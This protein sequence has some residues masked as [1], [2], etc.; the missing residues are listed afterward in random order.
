VLAASSTTRCLCLLGPGL[1]TAGSA[2]EGPLLLGAATAAALPAGVAAFLGV[3]GLRAACVCAP[4]GGTKLQ[5]KH[6]LHEDAA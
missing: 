5:G 3:A 1:P 6:S 2:L 4:G